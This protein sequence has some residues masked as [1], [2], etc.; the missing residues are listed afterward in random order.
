M[1][2]ECLLAAARA[3]EKENFESACE[4]GLEG[5]V[6]VGATSIMCSSSCGGLRWGGMGESCGGIPIWGRTS[7]RTKIQGGP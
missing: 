1:R 3:I 2:I 6:G 4:R 7:S 5:C